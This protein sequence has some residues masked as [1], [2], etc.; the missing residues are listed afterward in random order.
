MV[1]L[2]TTRMFRF[3]RR[4]G[5]DIFEKDDTTIKDVLNEESVVYSLDTPSDKCKEL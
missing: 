5:S 2:D 3:M 1:N 4:G